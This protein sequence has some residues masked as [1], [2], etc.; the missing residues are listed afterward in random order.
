[1]ALPVGRIENASSVLG[2][3]LNQ[4]LTQ[5]EDFF[6]L[7]PKEQLS[8]FCAT[9]LNRTIGPQDILYLSDQY[10]QGFQT[11]VRM[12]CLD[13]QEFAGEIRQ[14]KVKAEEAAA[15]QAM[16]L[17]KAEATLLLDTAVKK[18]K[19]VAPPTPVQPVRKMRRLDPG[20]IGMP[21]WV[22]QQSANV[23]AS[24]KMELSTH[25]ARI[26]R[27][28]MEKTDICFETKE[29]DE[30]GFQAVLRLNCLPGVWSTRSF[31]GQVCNKKA[32]AE[33]STAGVALAA[34]KKDAFLMSPEPQG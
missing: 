21:G 32:E 18:R 14:D 17:Y 22:A 34:I 31:V 12:C 28:I 27:K 16:L 9:K 25:C 5:R 19:A 30:G 3:V 20:V 2:P 26:A 24:N 8:Y 1:M 23:V 10:P 11:V 29:V 33:Q 4:Q 15:T 6:K 13:G 7:G